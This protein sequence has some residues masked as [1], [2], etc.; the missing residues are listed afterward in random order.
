M[1]S[2]LTRDQLAQFLPDARAIKAFE[3]LFLVATESTPET[4]EDLL[5]LV[6][7]TKNRESGSRPRIDELEQSKPRMANLSALESRVKE[8]EMQLARRDTHG[9]LLRRIEQLEQLIGA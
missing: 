9:D 7:S 3:N 5:I 1:A 6:N 2:P 4:L 8:L